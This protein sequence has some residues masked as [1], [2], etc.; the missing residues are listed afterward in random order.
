MF[1]YLARRIVWAVGLFLVVTLVTYVIFFMIPVD[2]ARQACGQRATATCINLARHTLGLDRPAYVQYGRFL[3]RLTYHHDLGRSFVTRQSVNSTVLN[4]AP[5]TASIAAG[6]MILMLIVAFPLGILSALR[7]RSKLDRAAMTF[8]LASISLPTFWVGLVAAYLVSFKLGLTP[9]A[10]YCD[11]IHPATDCGGPVQWA[12]HLVLPWTVFALHHSAYYIR[13]IRATLMEAMNED[14]VKVARAKGAP[15]HRVVGSHAMR[16]AVLPIVT[17]LGMDLGF[18]LG[19]LFF[20][21]YVFALPGLGNVAL[22]SI[23]TFDL[24]V[25]MGVVIFG[26]LAILVANLVVD[27]LYAVIDPRIRLA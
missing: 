5:V 23:S 9:I 22:D 21:E 1:R 27:L 13:M 25:T 17:M 8:T 14:Y 3:W 15:E 6:G 2:P 12:W 11:M 7:P 4:A 10:G 18:V 19:G 16:N 24:P 20:L 26:T